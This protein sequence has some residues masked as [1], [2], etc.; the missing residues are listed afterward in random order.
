VRIDRALGGRTRTHVFADIRAAGVR[1]NVHDIRVQAQPYY[2]RL[3]FRDGDFPAAE[4]FYA[5]ALSLP[6]YPTL[7]LEHQ[8]IVVAALTNALT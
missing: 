2:L 4:Q 1:V 7:P 5:Q 6:L 8:D 3:G